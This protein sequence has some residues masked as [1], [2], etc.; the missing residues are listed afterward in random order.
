VL[1]STV[2]DCIPVTG[3]GSGGNWAGNLASVRPC[4]WFLWKCNWT[5]RMDERIEL[6]VSVR[7]RV[8]C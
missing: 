6:F 8:L 5:L 2:I 3:G 7:L 1:V 4:E